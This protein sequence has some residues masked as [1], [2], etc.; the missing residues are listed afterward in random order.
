MATLEVLSE[1]SAHTQVFYFSHHQFLV[2]A[3]KTMFGHPV[4]VHHLVEVPE[5][6]TV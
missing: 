1:L 3:A 5:E 4:V 2:D 6:S